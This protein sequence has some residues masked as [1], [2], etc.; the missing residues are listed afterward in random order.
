MT[1]V[2]APGKSSV[3]DGLAAR[4]DRSVHVRGDTFRRRVVGGRVDPAP[5]RRRRRGVNSRPAP[6]SE[7]EVSPDLPRHGF[8]VVVQ[9]VVLAARLPAMAD[10]IGGPVWVGLSGSSLR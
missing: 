6:P 2:P 7:H 10:A 9:D 3:A 4:F 8:T 1:G 5:A